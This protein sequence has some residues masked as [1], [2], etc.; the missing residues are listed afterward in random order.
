MRKCT[1]Y[2]K[3]VQLKYDTG[4]GT[5]IRLMIPVPAAVSDFAAP[6]FIYGFI[7]ETLFL[8]DNANRTFG[9]TLAAAGTLG[10]IDVCH[11]VNDFNRTK[12]TLLHAEPAS[13]AAC[14]TCLLDSSTAVMAGAAH[15]ID[16]GIRYQLDQTARAGSDTFTAGHTLGAVYGSHAIMNRYSAEWTCCRTRTE[17]DTSIVT[18][19]R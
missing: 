15:R 4:T 16:C 10:V 8:F 7:T 1:E 11:I 13:D 14:G 9:S 19:P 6:W 5:G 17:T 12:F 2:E 18:G 3:R